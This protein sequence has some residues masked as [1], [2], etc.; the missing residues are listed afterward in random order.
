MPNISSTTLP[1]CRR[2]G[3]RGGVL[4]LALLRDP[5]EVRL[6]PLRAGA[7][8]LAV[9][10]LREEVVFFFVVV[11]FRAVEAGFF[12]PLRPAEVFFCAMS[13]NL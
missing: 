8:F 13:L 1:T 6:L 7:F 3:W 2:T 11:P 10:P 5:D 4:V 9:V 12:V